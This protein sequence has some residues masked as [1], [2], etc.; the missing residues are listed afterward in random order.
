MMCLGMPC[1]LQAMSTA[2]AAAGTSR[3]TSIHTSTSLHRSSRMWRFDL[4]YISL[5]S[6]FL[7]TAVLRAFAVQS[8]HGPL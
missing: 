4:V 5:D 8:L 1:R 2:A 6:A 7:Q 3:A